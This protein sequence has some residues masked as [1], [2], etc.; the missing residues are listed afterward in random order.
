LPP[1]TKETGSG[2]EPDQTSRGRGRRRARAYRGAGAEASFVVVAALCSLLRDGRPGE[3]GQ[4]DPAAA[5]GDLR[6][7]TSGTKIWTRCVVCNL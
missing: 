5:E 6:R 2:G 4:G 1:Q 3:R 7:R